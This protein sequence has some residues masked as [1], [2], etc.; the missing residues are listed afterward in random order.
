M[1]MRAVADRLG[2]LVLALLFVLA[3]ARTALADSSV[4]QALFDAGRQLM[5]E[6]NYAAA[7]AKFAESQ[8]IEPADGTLMN[9]AACHVKQGKTATAWSEFNDALTGAM[10]AGDEARIKEAKRQVDTL[11][12]EL[13][14]LRIVAAHGEAGLEIRLDDTL[15]GSATLGLAIPVDPGEHRVT[16]RAPGYAAWQTR[17]SVAPRARKELAVPA[18]HRLPRRIGET[19][20]VPRVAKPQVHDSAVDRSSSAPLAAYVIGGVGVVGLGVGTYFGL[21]A[22]S[23]KR[24]SEDECHNGACTPDGAAL[25]RDADSAAWVSNVGFGVGVAG[26][27]IATY[28]FVSTPSEE[29]VEKSL[30]VQP[31][32]G[33]GA[34]GLDAKAVW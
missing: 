1:R 23:K 27:G 22:G 9:L 24:D 13:S 18:L 15:L 7:C 3:T 33:A 6:G 21:K 10:R 25:L 4:A 17:V 12:P 20:S 30:S 31:F 26:I 5:K 28:L 29:K 14:R 32:V 11:E 8:R 34:L 16:V 2:T 19:H